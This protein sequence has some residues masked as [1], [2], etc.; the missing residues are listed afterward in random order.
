[1]SE[2]DE[3]IGDFMRAVTMMPPLPPILLSVDAEVAR[4]LRERNEA[5]AK[6][7]RD[8][9]VAAKL[10]EIERLG[11]GEL[12]NGTVV[13][14]R[15]AYDDGVKVY[16]YAAIKVEGSWYLTGSPNGIRKSNDDFC[17]W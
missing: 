2:I 7:K 13:R 8:A 15:K 1:M 4:T 10:T 5:S 6:L 3:T 9:E 12:S 17:I 16:S 11:T 14:F